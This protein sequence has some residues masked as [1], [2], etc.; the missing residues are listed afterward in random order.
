MMRK[1]TLTLC[2]A[3]AMALGASAAFAD[4]AVPENPC[5]KSPSSDAAAVAAYESCCMA[6]FISGQKMAVE[7]HQTAISK[8]E[9]AMEQAR[10]EAG[11]K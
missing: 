8:A 7:N 2:A 10:T 1:N 9:A 6:D 11:S 4:T 3:V 5:V